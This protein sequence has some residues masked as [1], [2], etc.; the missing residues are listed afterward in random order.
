MLFRIVRASSVGVVAGGSTFTASE[1]LDELRRS[2][3]GVLDVK[4]QEVGSGEIYDVRALERLIGK[5][6]K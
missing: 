1:A 5:M 2:S 6:G 3:G 4:A